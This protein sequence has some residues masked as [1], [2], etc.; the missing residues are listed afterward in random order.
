MAVILA[1]TIRACESPRGIHNRYAS[2]KDPA[3]FI[4]N[5]LPQASTWASRLSVLRCLCNFVANMFRDSLRFGI[6]GDDSVVNVRGGCTVDQQAEQFRPTVVTSRVHDMLPLVDQREIE[7]DDDFTFARA[8][9]LTQ[10][11]PIGCDN[12]GEATAGDRTD[13]GDACV[14]G[15]LSLLVSIQPGRSANDKAPS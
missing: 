1:S 10:Y 7:V 4:S 2:A 14:R 9:R 5:L 3:E 8:N 12:R 15:K 13:V 6:T 11:A